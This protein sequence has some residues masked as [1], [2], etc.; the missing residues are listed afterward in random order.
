MAYTNLSRKLPLI[1]QSCVY[2]EKLAIS[3]RWQLLLPG[4]IELVSIKIPYLFASENLLKTCILLIPFRKR[5]RWIA[6][7]D[8]C[9]AVVKLRSIYP[10]LMGWLI[11]PIPCSGTSPLPSYW[12]LRTL[13]SSS[14][15]GHWLVKYYKHYTFPCF[16]LIYYF[17]TFIACLLI[18]I[19]IISEIQQVVYYQWW[20]LIGCQIYL[21]YSGLNNA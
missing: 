19:I 2:G 3:T 7:L 8:L 16:Y 20:V 5:M 1:W 14:P 21:Y 13:P 9:R 10:S 6:V 17:M 18:I 15:P 4:T 11:S 12:K